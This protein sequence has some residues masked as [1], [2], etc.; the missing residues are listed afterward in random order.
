MFSK[1]KTKALFSKDNVP[2]GGTCLSSFMVISNG[3]RILVGKMDRPEIWV[4]KFL[5]GTARA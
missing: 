5:V 1:S 4:E 2:P 3:Q